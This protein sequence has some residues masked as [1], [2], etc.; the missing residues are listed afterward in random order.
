MLIVLTIAFV[1]TIPSKSVSLQATSAGTSLV[2]IAYDGG[3]AEGHSSYPAISA[4]GRY[5]AFDSWASNLVEGGSHQRSVYVRDMLTGTNELVSVSTSNEQTSATNPSIS[6]DGRFVVFETSMANLVPGD[7]NNRYDIFVRDRQLRQTE[8]I[9]VSSNEDQANDNAFSASIS[10]DGRFIAFHSEASNLTSDDENYYSDV[11]VRDRQAGTTELVSVGND[12]SQSNMTSR[13]PSI[14]G[15]GRYVVFES[16]ATNLVPGGTNGGYDI[17]VRD[18][19]THTTELIS[20]SYQ[21]EEINYSSHFPSISSDGRYVVFES[22][23]NLTADDTNGSISDIFVRDRQTGTIELASRSLAGISGNDASLH[24][25]IS[26]NGRY[27][28]YTSRASNI[29]EDDS[30]GRWDIFVYDRY[31]RHTKRASVSSNDG[32]SNSNSGEPYIAGDTNAVVFYSQAT[33]LIDGD[34]NGVDDIFMHEWEDE[35]VP[36]DLSIVTVK[37][38]QVLEDQPLVSGKGTAIKVVIQKTGSAP[39][40]DDV[41]VSASIGPAIY[42]R[43]FVADDDNMDDE[44][45][46]LTG[47]QAAYP[48]NFPAGDAIKTIFFFDLG[49]VPS[50]STFQTTATVDPDA[51]IPEGDETNNTTTSLEFPVVETS[52]L[53]AGGPDLDFT[54]FRT[55]WG[56]N[57]ISMFNEYVQYTNDYLKGVFPLAESQYKSRS[58]INMNGNTNLFRSPLNGKLSIIGLSRWMAYQL[59][60]L[61]L[62][63]QSTDR[64]I[65]VVPRGWFFLNTFNEFG[66]PIPALGLHIQSCNDIVFAEARHTTWPNGPSVVAHEIGHSY[67]L[68]TQCEEYE[69][70]NPNRQDGIGNIASPGIWVDK[71]LTVQ[72]PTQRNVYCFMGKYD[73][74]EYWIDSEDYQTFLND[75]LVGNQRYSFIQTEQNEAILASG[76]INITGTVSLE[77][78]YIVP[79]AEPDQL[80]PGPYSFVYLNSVGDTLREIPF[81]IKFKLDTGNDNLS[82][83]S[84]PFVFILPTMTGISRIEIRHNDTT[85]AEKVVSVH[86]PLVNLITPTGGEVIGNSLIIQWTGIDGDGDTLR[87]TVLLSSD[88]GATW[89][90]LEGDLTTNN[91]SWNTTGLRPGQTY[92][93]KVI[94][95]DGF[96]TDE[97]ISDAPFTIL[98]HIYLPITL[99]SSR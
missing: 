23:A 71:K 33:N 50:G 63:D 26:N 25:S 39:I 2:S 10:A 85:V 94:A 7:T 1:S 65:S 35:I 83:D 75:H 64:F 51:V 46:T 61:R 19:Q 20:I 95:T 72:I 24:A 37:P 76:I 32:Q 41:L 96:N 36:L 42:T 62:A 60:L 31:S 82:L 4:D 80:T 22:F 52:W 66:D 55:D 81:D 67:G 73:L 84:T 59:R 17:Y 9:S 88:N 91:L 48:L 99:I 16:D 12:G 43:F 56:F 70:C 29:V 89:E 8:R 57:P 78:W 13:Y 6:P 27:I 49:L 90:P 97:D 86:S 93:L 68:D 14:S 28:T 15:D 74:Q 34:T 79:E 30:N 38:L 98:D 92:R 21:G 3:L 54:Y 69:D 58:P 40:N 11:F 87:Y 5:V 44:N 18:R 47:D 53:E 77:D 45:H